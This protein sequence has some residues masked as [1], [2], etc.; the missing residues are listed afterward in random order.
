MKFAVLS[1]SLAVSALVLFVDVCAVAQPSRSPGAS[2]TTADYT[3]WNVSGD[4]VVTFTGDE[5]AGVSNGPYGDLVRRPPG[6]ARAG[7]IRPRMNFVT[8]LL[9]TVENL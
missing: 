4:Q 6:V 5:L 9:T 1:C 7:L 3:E 8:E 2:V